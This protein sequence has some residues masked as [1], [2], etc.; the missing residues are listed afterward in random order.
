MSYDEQATTALN[1][2][3]EIRAKLG[4]MARDCEDILFQRTIGAET[5]EFSETIEETLWNNYIGLK[6]ELNTLISELP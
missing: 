4:E 2:I 5:I 6:A 3:A 1:K